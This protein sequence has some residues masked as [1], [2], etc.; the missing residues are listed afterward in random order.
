M[1]KPVLVGVVL[2]VVLA[3]AA[4]VRAGSVDLVPDWTSV[5]S[6]MGPNGD[7]AFDA[8][9]PAV[10]FSPLSGEFLTV[11]RVMTIRVA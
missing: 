6:A 9:G 11:W 1:K 3:A 8:F 10:A 2:C 5:V 7:P 4:P